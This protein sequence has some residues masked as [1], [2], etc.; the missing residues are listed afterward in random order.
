MMTK[1]IN[2]SKLQYMTILRKHNMS[3]ENKIH[4]SCTQKTYYY[5]WDTI[6]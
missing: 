6:Q 1:T 3:G 2:N 5:F 4:M